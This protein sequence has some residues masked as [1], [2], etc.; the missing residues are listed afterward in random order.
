MQQERLLTVLNVLTPPDDGDLPLVRWL[1]TQLF[2]ECGDNLI[3]K[4]P[5]YMECPERIKLGQYVFINSCCY[6]HAG[7]DKDSDGTITI[8]DF[9]KIGPGTHI[10]SIRH[11]PYEKDGLLCT[12]NDHL[13][14][15]LEDHCKIGGGCI[16]MPGVVIGREAIIGSGSVVTKSIPARCMAAGNPCRIIRHYD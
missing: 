15:H 8:G 6:F 2:K 12:S 5:I 9:V 14:V 10:Y 3:L 16:I 13:P 11:S 7:N 1:A 4:P